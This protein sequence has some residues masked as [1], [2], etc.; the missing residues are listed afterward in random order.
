[1]QNSLFFQKKTSVIFKKSWY[2]NNSRIC[3]RIDSL[4][5]IL[6]NL[7]IFLFFTSP[8]PLLA[9]FHP[10]CSNCPKTGLFWTQ[11]HLAMRSTPKRTL[12]GEGFGTLPSRQRNSWQAERL[13]MRTGVPPRGR[14]GTSWLWLGKRHHP[15]PMPQQR[16]KRVKIK[17][18][19]GY[20]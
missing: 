13:P 15:H 17:N 4:F 12:K 16:W 11:S 8:P 19:R 7:H 14:E 18:L 2:V 1:M 10:G 5:F 9:A 6:L 20:N 3:K